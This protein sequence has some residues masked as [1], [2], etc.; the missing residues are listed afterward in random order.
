MFKR[1]FFLLF[2][3][4]FSQCNFFFCEQ[5]IRHIFYLSAVRSSA[6][7]RVCGSSYF[8]FIVA[9][10]VGYLLRT[11]TTTPLSSFR[12]RVEKKEEKEGESV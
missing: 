12:I 4:E 8:S 1:I 3:S 10:F 7:G 6:Y 9:S 5:E 2:A 11:L